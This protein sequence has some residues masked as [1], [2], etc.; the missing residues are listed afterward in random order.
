MVEEGRSHVAEEG[1]VADRAL[2]FFFLSRESIKAY[3]FYICSTHQISSLSD[4]V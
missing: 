3:T 1:R 4:N 2:L